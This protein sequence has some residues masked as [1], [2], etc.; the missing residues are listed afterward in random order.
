MARH[1]GIG[2]LAHL[3]GNPFDNLSKIGLLRAPLLIIH[4]TEDEVV[5]FAMGQRLFEQAPYPKQFVPLQGF[6][7]NDI[8]LEHTGGYRTA[9]ARF[10]ASLLST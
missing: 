9:V 10:I 5:P 1:S 3:V 6:G 7:H 2:L 8:I 4:G